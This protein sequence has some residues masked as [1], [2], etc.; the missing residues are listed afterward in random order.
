[1]MALS[2]LAIWV[3]FVLLVPKRGVASLAERLRA[4]ARADR[5]YVFGPP[6]QLGKRFALSALG[7][8]IRLIEV[9][10]PI[11]MCCLWAEARGRR[12]RS[13]TPVVAAPPM[14]PAPK[15]RPPAPRIYRM[16]PI[17]W[18]RE[19][20]ASLQRRANEASQSTGSTGSVP[21]KP[22]EPPLVTS[23]RLAIRS[24]G[25]LQLLSGN[26]DLTSRLVRAPTLS[27]IWLFLLTHGAA[28]PGAK[29]HRQVLA[30]EAF[31]GI[32]AEQQRARLR[33]R[34]SDLQREPF[35]IVLAE[36]IKMDGD[37]LQ[38]EIE[39]DEF[40]LGR[41]R[42]TVE[43]FA[44][45]SGLLTE[46]G[47]KAIQRAIGDYGGEYL[48]IWDE[49]ERQTTSGRGSASDLVRAVR[50][51]AE[52]FRLQ[53]LM[54][55]AHHHRAR[56]DDAEAIPLLEEVLRRRPDR[57]DVARLAMETYR[58]TGQITRARQLETTYRPEFVAAE[59]RSEIE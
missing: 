58:E 38:L 33:G 46:T 47:V 10:I 16:P 26:Q 5:L 42:R 32:D 54:R 1:M 25:T 52:D 17:E 6:P 19:W 34:L 28:R 9:G 59:R 36:R 22:A 37:L 56:H 53:L 35:P 39:A 51:L 48:P 21:E 8:A 41:L 44:T 11:Y 20:E 49:I 45:G 50:A 13:A 43:E 40:D 7:E 55:L 15:A 3:L 27:F 57:E 4:A 12:S 2:L 31:P 14:P 30:E 29:V 18:T 24:L 23:R